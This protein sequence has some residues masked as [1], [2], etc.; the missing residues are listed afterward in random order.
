M[1]VACRLLYELAAR[2]QDLIQFKFSSFV[3]TCDDIRVEWIPKK[4]A[5]KKIKRMGIIS[6]ET[7]ELI[8]QL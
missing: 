3:E 1:R 6:S 4:T 5:R 2:C 7:L 8:K